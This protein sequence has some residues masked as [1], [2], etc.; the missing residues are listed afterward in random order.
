M[1]S[2]A[3]KQAA[4]DGVL[5]TIPY[6]VQLE[7]TVTDPETVAQLRAR[8]DGR[9]RDEYAL[10]ALRLGVLALAHTVAATNEAISTHITLDEKDAALSRL[11]RE[12][13]DALGEHGKENRKFQEEVRGTLE[14]M[15]ARQEE[16][17]ESARP[18]G[19]FETVV[20]EVVQSETQ[21]LKD[22]ATAVGNSTGLIK[23]CKKGDAIVELGP[24]SAASGAKIVVEAKE[25]ASYDLAEALTE[26]AIARQ[27]RAADSGLFVFSKKVAPTGLEPL[28]RYGDDVVVV[29]DADD[30]TTDS[31]LRI[32]LSMAGALCIRKALE[33][34]KM[35]VDFTAIDGRCW[36]SAGR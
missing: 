27:N 2:V 29:W 5:D 36:R 9:E 23:N 6:P 3:A 28:A 15:Q 19:D 35:D 25:D 22:I 14:R 1:H 34:S 26:M 24:E 13:M 12:P 10:G 4:R 33:R 8:R 20:F 30:P 11:R 7:L 32:G 18:G 16:A 17:A 31:W 21:R